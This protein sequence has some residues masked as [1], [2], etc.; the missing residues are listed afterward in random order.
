MGSSVLRQVVDHDQRVLA[1]ITEILRHRESGGGRNPLQ[2]GRACRTGN[3]D[4]AALRGSVFLDRIDGAAYARALLANRDI[5]ADDIA[6][7]LI[8]NRVDRDRR[9]ADGT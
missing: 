9:L 6:R 2:S 5:D 1:A 8:D 3:D 7:L 4:D